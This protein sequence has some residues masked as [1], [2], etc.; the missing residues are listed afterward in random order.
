MRARE[1]VGLSLCG[2]VDGQGRWDTGESV[3]LRFNR[4]TNAV[5][6]VTMTYILHVSPGEH[7]TLWTPEP[8]ALNGLLT[9]RCRYLSLNPYHN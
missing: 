5:S 4:I 3:V 8:C 9:C 7:T 6:S 2:A 1:R